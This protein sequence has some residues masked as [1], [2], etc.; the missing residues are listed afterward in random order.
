MHL[1]HHIGLPDLLRCRQRYLPISREQ[2]RIFCP[3]EDFKSWILFYG[4]HIDSLCAD[5]KFID[6][7][8]LLD[9]KFS[10]AINARERLYLNI[11]SIKTCAVEHYKKSYALAMSF[12]YRDGDKVENFR[13]AYSGDTGLSDDFV[14]LGY[15]AD[16]L[17]HEA[18]FQNVL[19]DL[20]DKF[21]HSTISMALEQS[22]KMQ[23]KHTILTHFS[24]RYHIIPYIEDLDE[25]AGLAF[26]F[27]EVTLDDLPKLHSLVEQYHKA[28]PGAMKIL[29]RKKMNY[30]FQRGLDTPINFE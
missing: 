2:L 19:R 13:L 27:M 29:E 8:D 26:D 4:N 3:L 25:N 5:I 24:S 15:K 12:S 11:N 22:K 1:D 17:I 18:T 28:F 9:D 14:K 6:N 23:A 30:H 16:L 21:R 7:D 10:R 20:A